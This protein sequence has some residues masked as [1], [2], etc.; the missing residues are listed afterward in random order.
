[1]VRIN[2]SE[3]DVLNA[4]QKPVKKNKY[5]AKRVKVNGKNIA[6]KKEGKRYIELLLQEKC[7]VISDLKTQV[8]YILLEA[9]VHKGEKI[10]K[11]SYFADFVYK[12]DG[13]T[14]VEETKGFKTDVYKIKRKLLLN[15]YPGI[16]FIET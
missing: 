4:G 3:L 5:N 14:Y 9:F 15:R 6:S 11:I 8:E 12:R 2:Q 16:T 13:V 1:M 7:G 10:R